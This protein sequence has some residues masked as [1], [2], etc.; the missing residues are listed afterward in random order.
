[1]VYLVLAGLVLVLIIAINL[2]QAE[3]MP[4]SMADEEDRENRKSQFQV[5]YSE[6]IVRPRAVGDRLQDRGGSL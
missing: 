3:P 2:A 5:I 4:E 6:W 1:M